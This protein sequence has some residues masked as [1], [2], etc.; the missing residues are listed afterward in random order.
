MPELEAG[1]DALQTPS[2]NTALAIFNG[3][4]ARP[5]IG[6][7]AV[8]LLVILAGAVQSIDLG[9]VNLSS[10]GS[11]RLLLVF[12]ALL[13]LPAFIAPAR[14][15]VRRQRLLVVPNQ[16]PPEANDVDFM[17]TM[18]YS[19]MP[20]AFVKRVERAR[21]SESFEASD[22]F[23]SR[24]FDEIQEA[25]ENR[26][27][28][29]GLPE[30]VLRDHHQGDEEALTGRRSC[31]LEVPPVTGRRRLPILTMKT[32]FKHKGKDYIAGWYL[33]VDL[34]ELEIKDSSTE[35]WLREAYDQPQMRPSV[36]S[37]DQRGIRVSVG[38]AL[39]QTASG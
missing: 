32:H 24:A 23:Y 17:F 9:W 26:S 7:L 21:G 8:G 18:F 19:A 29:G 4:R 15:G 13:C 37:D 12:G 31:Q 14:G 22:I 34:A 39:R 10:R 11:Q 33:P 16:L 27:D 6:L 35:L 25:M 20:P 30:A 5:T 38:E 3:L 28:S 36:E 1:D 2:A